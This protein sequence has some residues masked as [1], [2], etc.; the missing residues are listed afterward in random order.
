MVTQLDTL[1]LIALIATENFNRGY[2]VLSGKVKAIPAKV[3]ILELR[4]SVSAVGPGG[5]EAS[6]VI[7]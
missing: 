6:E 4:D 2:L 7:T 3:I 5:R 1:E